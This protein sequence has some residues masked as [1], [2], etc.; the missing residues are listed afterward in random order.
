M[1]PSVGQLADTGV[2]LQKPGDE[3][4]TDSVSYGEG[5]EKVETANLAS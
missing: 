1:L 3:H 2:L 4:A 5:E